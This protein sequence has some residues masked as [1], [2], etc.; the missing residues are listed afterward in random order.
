[1]IENLKHRL[2]DR[3]KTIAFAI[4][5]VFFLIS[6]TS[7]LNKYLTMDESVYIVAGYSYL[8]TSDFRINWEHPVFMKA[9]Y[10]LPLLFL[11]PKL[12]TEYNQ[13]WERCA[14]ND[15][16]ASY[17]FASDFYIQN[18]DMLRSIIF[19]PRIVAIIV[20]TMLG[21]TVFLWARDAFGPRAGIFALILYCFEPNI[22]AHGSIATLD[23]PMTFFLF[24][25]FY[26]MW[27]FIKSGKKRFIML[28]GLCIALAIMTKYT[29]LMFVPLLFFFSLFYF[30]EVRGK[31]KQKRPEI[32]KRQTIF[33]VLLTYGTILLCLILPTLVI[34]NII[35]S[36]DT[37]KEKYFYV[38]PARV[39]EGY[40]FMSDWV[41]GG[42][43]GWFFGQFRQY[44][45][46]Y[47]LGSFLIKTTLPFLLFSTFSVIL[48]SFSILKYLLKKT[49]ISKEEVRLKKA[50]IINLAAVAFPGLIFFMALS[51]FGRFYIGF[52]Y[53]LPAFPFLI[54][55]VSGNISPHIKNP[56]K[57]K[58]KIISIAIM[59]VLCWHIVSAVFIYPHY[60]AYFNELIGGPANGPKYLTDSSID[61]GQ[62]FFYFMDFAK[63]R[64]W[65][66]PHLIY[67]GWPYPT[68]LMKF[69]WEDICE[70]REDKFA[71]SVSAI[72]G[73]VPDWN[74]HRWLLNYEPKERIGWTIYYY[75]FDRQK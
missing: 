43:E 25:S 33:F 41:Q 9:L 68:F 54:V 38:L 47:Y 70:W 20:A 66:N 57:E 16:P 31:A 27:K 2:K 56:L 49:A 26:T 8:K 69:Y 24:S 62:D 18:K 65:D 19:W 63:K 60:L 46:E 22:I 58:R 45:P 14:N 67:F 34:T 61:W 32:K 51:I 39:F 55:F 53:A 71:I 7:I 23:I 40:K 11:N 4:L 1:M 29:A 10:G 30:G 5:A 21:A 52:R 59:T 72:T 28:S 13:N 3:E 15:V 50:E 36:F 17:G 48:F 73:V 37:Y 42:R 64:N 6:T 12:P 74:C 35:Y 75:E 44:I